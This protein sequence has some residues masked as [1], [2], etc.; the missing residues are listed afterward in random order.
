MR[1]SFEGLPWLTL[2]FFT[3]P[4]SHFV[5]TLTKP[6]NLKMWVSLT[7]CRRLWTFE[8]KSH[9]VCAFCNW[10]S[11]NR[12][13]LP[14][15]HLPYIHIFTICYV[16]KSNWTECYLLF[17]FQLNLILMCVRYLV[18]N[19]FNIFAWPTSFIP[20]LIGRVTT[21]PS[22]LVNLKMDQIHI[23]NTLYYSYH[24]VIK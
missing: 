13:K 3:F 17:L 23:V 18:P 7:L 5:K 4:S 10:E 8:I 6:G 2:D 20:R 21:P 12:C 15:I 16:G 1:L 9:T 24:S 14:C 19:H 22:L 11:N